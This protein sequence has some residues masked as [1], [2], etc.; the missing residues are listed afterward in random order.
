MTQQHRTLVQILRAVAE[1]ATEHDRVESLRRVPRQIRELLRFTF[2]D[3]SVALP[4]GDV[5]VAPIPARAWRD[6]DAGGVGDDDL[7]LNEC[8]KL[9]R[10][11]AVGGHATLSAKRRL[12]L[13]RDI[14]ERL[15]ADERDLLEH[16]RLHR[17]FPS[18]LNRITRRAVDAAFPGLCEAPVVQ[19]STPRYECLPGVLEPQQILDRPEPRPPTAPRTLSL[20][21][22][23]YMELMRLNGFA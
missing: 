9:I 13:W 3:H 8:P 15:P 19:A 6:Q 11:F 7:L 16:I 18:V 5:D 1:Q 2:G 17:C 20:D 14:L 23:R 4:D 10:L 22:E 12:E 21:E